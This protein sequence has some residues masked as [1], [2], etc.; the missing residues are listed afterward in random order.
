[1]EINTSNKSPLHGA[2]GRII[3]F[4]TLYVI[5]ELTKMAT[6]EKNSER[7]VQL[8]QQLINLQT[9]NNEQRKRRDNAPVRSLTKNLTDLLLKRILQIKIGPCLSTPGVDIKK[10]VTLPT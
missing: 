8:I 7:Y 9:E 10:C 4:S 3:P 1:M 2:A 6:G 5:Q